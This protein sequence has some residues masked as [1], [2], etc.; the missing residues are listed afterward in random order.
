MDA[1]NTVVADNMSFLILKCEKKEIF[2]PHQIGISP[3]WSDN[4][5]F[6]YSCVFEIKDY[7]L[8]LK[9]LILTSD[10][11]YPN[12]G[13]AKPVFLSDENGVDTVEY[14]N[15]MIPVVYTGAILIGKNLVKTYGN[16]R[17]MPCYSFKTVRELIFQEGRLVTTIDHSK[18]MLRIRKN[19][20]LGLRDLNKKRD[21]K[22]IKHFLKSS[23]VGN[24]K[25]PIKN[26]EK[27]KSII[28]FLRR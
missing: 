5:N 21:L 20:D 1:K 14:R 18:A 7:Q 13:G 25:T 4:R 8:Y 17:E 27:K 23:F 15:V 2:D 12:V 26:R 22:C 24:Y 9:N 16:E 3:I 19:L 10:R 11:I 6:H 28:K